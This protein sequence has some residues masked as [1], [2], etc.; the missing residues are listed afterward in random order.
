MMRRLFLLLLS[1]VMLSC[2]TRPHPAI[3]EFFDEQSANTV[4]VTQSPLVF[5]RERSDVAAHARDFVTLV[6]VEIDESGEYHAYLIAYRWSTVDR[7][8]WPEPDPAAGLL[9]II[10]DG[11][12]MELKPLDRLPIGLTRRKDLHVPNRG[13]VIA[14]AYQPDVGMLRFIASSRDLVVRMPQEP[15]DTPFPLL[16]DGRAAL[17]EFLKRAA[18]P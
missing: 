6:A 1:T 10:A 17:G 16:E 4:M 5:A 12:V 14:R 2:T 3:R 11:R 18:G 8:M 9:R 13:D 7:R 15:L